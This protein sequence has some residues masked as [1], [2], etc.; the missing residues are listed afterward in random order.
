MS[1]D[2]DA[3]YRRSDDVVSREI[4]GEL[5]IVPLAAGIGDLDDELYTM[6]ETGKAIWN[7]LDGQQTLRQIAADLL[8]SYSGAAETIESDVCGLIEE[9]ERRRMVVFVDPA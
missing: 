4:E 2:A 9:L 5:I 7:R 8:A 6:N 3:V 1:I